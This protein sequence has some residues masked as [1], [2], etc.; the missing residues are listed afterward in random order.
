MFFYEGYDCPVCGQSFQSNE[1]VVACP[2]C[3]LPHH[4]SCWMKEGHCHLYQLHN[5][6]EQWNR[7]NASTRT[8]AN[9]KEESSTHPQQLCP[10]CQTKNPEFAEICT[11]CGMILQP[12]DPFGSQEQASYHEYRPYGA[13]PHSAYAD[14]SEEI[15]GMNPQDLLAVVGTNTEYYIPRFRRIS[16]GKRL[17]W[18]WAA[19]LLTP[20]WLLY[21]KMYGYGFLMIALQLIETIM[22]SVLSG[23]LGITDTTTTDEA[24]STIS[25]VTTANP[26]IMYI[27]IAI[28]LLSG[29]IFL[30]K[31]VVGFYGNLLYQQHCKRIIIRSRRKIPDITAGELISVG[32]VSMAMAFIGYGL[33]FFITQIIN[34]LV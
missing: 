33:V 24:L 12:T 20:F 21:R 31:L 13:S 23:Q 30:L 6:P 18:N 25:S 16:G 14:S 26:S 9:N 34:I 22:V 7:A 2:E 32:G 3:G 29:A 17:S 4:R 27:A 15:D 10:R 11:H 5:T 1:D 8:G 28:T 19:F